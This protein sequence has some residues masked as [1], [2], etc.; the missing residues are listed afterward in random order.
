MR[1]EPPERVVVNQL[2]ELL[3][4]RA[5]A[6]LLREHTAALHRRLTALIDD[7]I[8]RIG[9]RLAVPSDS[10][11]RMVLALH[12]GLAIAHVPDDEEP[13]AAV[14]LERAALLLLLRSATTA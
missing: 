8:A 3:G 7:G 1:L 6:A 2:V 10:L 14:E 9:V 5:A 4:Q 13:D 12:D 11:A